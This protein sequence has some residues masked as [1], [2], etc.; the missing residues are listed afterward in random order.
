M[1]ASFNSF[2]TAA[3]LTRSRALNLIRQGSLPDIA[4]ANIVVP[5]MTDVL[6]ASGL[7][8][9]NLTVRQ[10]GARVRHTHSGPM[11]CY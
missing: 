5:V 6:G 9:T 4:R 10:V 1:S 11:P 8:V 3:L 2:A 7:R